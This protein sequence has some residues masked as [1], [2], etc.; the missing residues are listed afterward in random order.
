[1]GVASTLLS[2][3]FSF[4]WEYELHLWCHPV[5]GAGVIS[6]PAAVLYGDECYICPESWRGRETWRWWAAK[7]V[8]RGSISYPLLHSFRHSFCMPPWEPWSV[9]SVNWAIHFSPHSQNLAL[10]SSM[11]LRSIRAI[12]ITHLLAAVHRIQLAHQAFLSSCTWAQTVALHSSWSQVQEWGPWRDAVSSL[13]AGS[14]GSGKRCPAAGRSEEDVT[15]GGH[16]LRPPTGL[17]PFLFSICEA[18]RL[19][20]EERFLR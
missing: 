10:R 12:V 19:T 16:M 3:Q 6:S 15:A 8:S 11:D 2:F 4:P 14:P 7:P 5:R 9:F 17:L 1:M 13:H 20:E 18:S